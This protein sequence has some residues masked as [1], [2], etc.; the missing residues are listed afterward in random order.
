MILVTISLLAKVF[1]FMFYSHMS[2]LLSFF[3]PYSNLAAFYTRNLAEKY[4]PLLQVSS[5]AIFLL[6]IV[7]M[8]LY[9][10]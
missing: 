3:F 1:I 7:E 4:P 6:D 10:V 8:T 2:N 9:N 5:L